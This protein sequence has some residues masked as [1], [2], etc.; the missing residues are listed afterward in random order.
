M[1][2]GTTVRPFRSMTRAPAGG[3]AGGPIATK[4]PPLIDAL[5]AMVLP[6]SIV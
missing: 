2:P 3:V 4:R 6:A 1:M 5:V